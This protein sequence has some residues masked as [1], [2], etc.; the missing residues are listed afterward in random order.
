MY[1]IGFAKDIHALKENRPLIICGEKIP[2]HLGAEAHS[3]GDVVYHAVSDA[4]LG[5]LSLRDIGYYFSDTDPKYK[6]IDSS[7]IVK[8]VM[9]MLKDK[10]FIIN[11]V[12]VFISLEKPK[13][14]KFIENMRKNLADLLEIDL[15]NV[16]IKAGTNEGFGD[17][18][19][20]KAIEAYAIV[21]IKSNKNN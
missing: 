1:K 6:N 8:E 12:D 9:Q 15:S 3:D 20:N 10:D 4:I 11:N 17:V 5:A 18:G 13:L 21:L 16:A 2:Y 14:S 7:I 19:Q